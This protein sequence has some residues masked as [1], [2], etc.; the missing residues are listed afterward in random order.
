MVVVLM[1]AGQTCTVPP[2][3]RPRAQVQAGCVITALDLLSPVSGVLGKA[4]ARPCSLS[5]TMII[6]LAQQSES[7]TADDNAAL[8]PEVATA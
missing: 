1:P 6:K 4:A 2:A 7:V 5:R 3:I 8:V